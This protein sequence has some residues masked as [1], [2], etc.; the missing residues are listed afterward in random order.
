MADSIIDGTLFNT[1]NIMYT[2]PKA[3]AQGAK[4]VNILNKHVKKGLVLSTP[5]SDII[6]SIGRICRVKHLN[7]QP[8]IIDIVDD[9]DE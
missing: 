8:I 1:A 4:S 5:K 3:T 7:I 9:F 6:Q 2:A